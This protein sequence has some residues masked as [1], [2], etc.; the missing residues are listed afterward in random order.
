MEIIGKHKGVC[1]DVRNM[2]IELT[3][4]ELKEQLKP[5]LE[6]LKRGN[7]VWVELQECYDI[8]EN[9]FKGINCDGSVSIYSKRGIIAIFPAEPEKK[10]LPDGL[11]NEATIQDII[12]AYNSLRDA[13]KELQE[14]G[15]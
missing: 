5:D 6:K 13:V 2:V 1:D 15:K 11:G 4:Q 8:K 3:P 9:T 10:E 14:K 7:T 12:Y